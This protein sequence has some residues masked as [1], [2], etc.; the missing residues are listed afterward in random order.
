MEH[1]Q[2]LIAIVDALGAA[3]FSENEIERFLSSRDSV[4][5]TLKRKARDR[6]EGIAADRVTEFT[7]GDT[8]LISYVTDGPACA[9]DIYDFS[10]ALRNSLVDSLANEILFR[11]SLAIGAFSV[12]DRTR[13]V[14]G[15]AVAD[16]AAWYN[17][18]DWIGVLAT[19]QTTLYIRSIAEQDHID[20][21]HVLVDYRIPIKKESLRE[22]TSFTLKAVNW[23][24]GFWVHQV[25][26]LAEGEKPKAKF[27]SL[28]AAH[29][30]PKGTESKYFNTVAFFDHCAGLYKAEQRK[31]KSRTPAAGER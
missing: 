28:L 20:L 26:P 31:K 14:M 7:F 30:V 4:V 17:S 10:E 23:P 22:Q 13:T 16:A 5:N 3:N 6:A 27:L 19:P 11:G 12:D 1:Q 15:A 8:V 2:G 29:R 18:A 9:K 25:R 21:E 24:R